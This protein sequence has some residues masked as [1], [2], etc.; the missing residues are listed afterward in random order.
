MTKYLLDTNITSTIGKDSHDGYRLLGK[1]SNLND[2]DTVSVSILTLYESNYGLKNTNNETQKLE[3]A[4]NINFLQRNFDIIPLDLKEMEIYADLKVAYKKLTGITRKE[5]KK[6]DLDLLIA[7]TS[8]AEDA[9]LVSNDKIFQTIS[10]IDNR[11]KY[12]NWLESKY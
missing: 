7:S 5:A 4:Q 9:T 8:I 10:K 3:I 2:D 12:E 6:N 11:L 1:L